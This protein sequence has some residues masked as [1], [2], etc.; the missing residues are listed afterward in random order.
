MRRMRVCKVRDFI[1]AGTSEQPPA[2]ALNESSPLLKLFDSTSIPMNSKPFVG[3]KHDREQLKLV[4][5]FLYTFF[6]LLKARAISLRSQSE[7]FKH[8]A[9]VLDHLTE[10]HE[11]Y[12]A[13]F[14]GTTKKLC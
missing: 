13:L 8:S 14:S 11:N 3:L 5:F 12:A 2:K 10:I 7:D 9:R 6:A 4:F 1:I